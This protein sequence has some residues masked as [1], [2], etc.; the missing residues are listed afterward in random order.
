MV[1]THTRRRVIGRKEDDT[2]QIFY[3]DEGAPV[4]I[5][6]SEGVSHPAMPG[7][8]LVKVR[9]A[10]ERILIIDGAEL[11]PFSR[12]ET[13]RVLAQRMGMSYNTLVKAAR[14]GRLFTRRSGAV[15]LTTEDAIRYAISQGKI[16][17]GI[18][19]ET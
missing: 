1:I 2:S 15:R 4:E 17:P 8:R 18:I 7:G 13:L 14:A 12:D 10:E 9:A 19:K 3:I 16:S 5:L 6:Q 11:E